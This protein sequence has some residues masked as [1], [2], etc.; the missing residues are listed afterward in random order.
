MTVLEN[1]IEV[2]AQTQ[3]DT[4]RLDRNVP[5]EAAAIQ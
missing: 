3:T 4:I 2:S 1:R 5:D